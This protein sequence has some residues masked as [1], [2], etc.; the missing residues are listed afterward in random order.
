MSIAPLA[1]AFLLLALPAHATATWRPPVP[2]PV[3]RTFDVG[4]NPYEG[5]HH[6]GIDLAARPGTTVRGACAGRV[7]VAGSVGASGGVVTVLCGHWRVTEMPLRTIAVRAGTTVTAGTTL[8]TLAAGHDHAGL[9]LGVR[10]DGVP[11]G[12]V[13]PLRFLTPTPATPSPPLGRG[14]KA[15]RPSAPNPSP[16]SAPVSSPAAARAATPLAPWA[17]WLGLALVLAG[18]GVRWRGR[19]GA[20]PRQRP[21]GGEAARS[22]RFVTSGR[23]A[24]Q[25][26]ETR[27]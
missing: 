7:V 17:A 25:T 5:G 19:R 3:S 6:R 20:G 4:A 13:D 27:R 21:L 14:P 2:G 18:A 8:G 22:V 16:V 24:P 10:R 23:T 9:H 1:V 11:F 12:Y 15:R 26:D